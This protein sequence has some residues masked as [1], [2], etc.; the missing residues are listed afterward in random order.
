MSYS[1]YKRGE[2]DVKNSPKDRAEVF[3]PKLEKNLF[4]LMNRQYSKAEKVLINRVTVVIVLA[5]N[6]V[7]LAVV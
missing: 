5:E 2:C 7:S 1:Q 4:C 3:P 6:R